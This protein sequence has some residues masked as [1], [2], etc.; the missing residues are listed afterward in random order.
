MGS[1]AGP[2]AAEAADHTPGGAAAEAA[3][4]GGG[5]SAAEAAGDCCSAEAAG[6]CKEGGGLTPSSWAASSSSTPR[7][8]VRLRPRPRRSWRS[9]RRRLPRGAMA[10]EGMRA[11]RMGSA[12]LR[13]TL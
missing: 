10:E 4:S 12:S 5:A 13:A 8:G 7:D 1:S 9:C 6:E 3:G 11:A 2:A